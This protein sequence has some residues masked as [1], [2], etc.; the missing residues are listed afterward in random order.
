MKTVGHAPEKPEELL[1]VKREDGMA[2]VWMRRNIS[3]QVH[4][5][6][7]DGENLDVHRAE[8]ALKR[9]LARLGAVD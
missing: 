6:D 2:D 3:P 1:Y 8:M 7:G 4:H 9:S 5:S